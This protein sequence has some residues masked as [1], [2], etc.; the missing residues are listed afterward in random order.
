MDCFHSSF[1]QK[2]EFIYIQSNVMQN[3][4]PPGSPE[5]PTGSQLESPSSELMAQADRILNTCLAENS[6]ANL[7][8][9]I[10]LLAQTWVN[11]NPEDSG[12]LKLLAASLSTRF[13]YTCQWMDVQLAGLMFLILHG[14][15]L[16][17]P[18]I[19]GIL[20]DEL[21]LDVWHNDEGTSDIVAL[22]GNIVANFHQSVNLANLN[23]AIALYESALS[24]RDFLGTNVSRACR[25]LASAQLIQFRVTGEI[26][27]I[28]RSISLLRQLHVVKP[29]QVS[30]LCAALLAK[31]DI[32]NIWDVT[33]LIQESVNSTEKT[34]ELAQI[35]T[36]I[37]QVSHD[38]GDVDMAISALEAAAAK[39]PWGHRDC[40]WILVNLCIALEQRFKRKG[41]LRDLDIAIRLRRDTVDLRP[42]PHPDRCGSLNDLG[43]VLHER[44]EAR[45][46]AADL[47]SAMELHQEAL[48]LC[49]ANHPKRASFFN[50]LAN[51]LHEQ[52]KQGGDAE[53]L[54][55]AI[56]LLD[57]ALN[58]RPPGHPG[59]GNSLNSLAAVLH[60]RFK[61]RGTEGDLDSAIRLHREAFDLFPGPEIR[62]HS[63]NNLAYIL[64]E[65]FQTRGDAGDLDNAIELH[66][67]ALDLRPAPHPNH[68]SSLNNLAYAL[69]ERF[70][71]R[72]EVADL[73][74][75]IVLLRDALDLRPP[76]HPYRA[77]SLN[78]LAGLLYDRLQ[79]NHDEGDLDSVIKLFREA[80]DLHQA[81]HP[82]RGSSLSH[83][84]TVLLQRFKTR[85][86]LQD[87]ETAI[88]L[89][90]EA[91]TIYQ[92][93]H[94]RRGSALEAHARALLDKYDNSQDF[95]ALEG[96][97]M[98]LRESSA[99][100]LT[101]VSQRFRVTTI[102]AWCAE[103]KSHSSALE[104]YE[105][106]IE[107]LPQQ[108]MLGLDIHSRQE[109]L[110]IASVH[111]IVLDAA[112]C[113]T[114]RNDLVKAVQFLEAGRSVFW[115]QALK[116]H[117]S[118]DD[119][120]AVHS[121]LAARIKNIAKKLEVG[122]YRDV[123]SIRML[124]ALHKSHTMLDE[125]NAYYRKL[126]AEWLQT[127]DEVRQLQGFQRFL[128]PKLMTELGAAAMFGPVIILKASKSACTAF[129][130]TLSGEVQAIH[131]TSMTWDKAQ[132][133]VE[134]LHALLSR[135]RVQII[136]TL[137]KIP[138]R[139][140]STESPPLQERLDGSVE[141]SADLDPNKV[142]G[143]LLGE[144][145]TLI[146]Q[147]VFHALKLKK[148]N[149]PSRLWW[150]TTGPFTFLP[151]HAAGL[152]EP[153]RTD[154]VSDYAVSSYTPTLTFLLDQPTRTTP[155]FKMTAVI[156]PETPMLPSLPATKDE[157]T[158]IQLKVPP[159]WLTSL[160][161]T[162]P[163]TVDNALQHLQESS[164]V[165]F[166][167]HGTQDMKNSLES[168]LH[169]SDGRLKLSE[170]MRGKSQNM[171]MTLAFLSACE[172]AKGNETVP[173]EVMHLAATLL[174]T[175]FRGVV[176][177]MWTMADP[178]GPKIAETFYE[179]LFKGCDANATPQVLPDLTKAA[180][181]LHIAVTKLRAD[182]KVPFSRWRN[183]IYD[184]LLPL[185]APLSIY[186]R[187]VSAGSAPERLPKCCLIFENF[188][189]VVACVNVGSGRLDQKGHG[190]PSGDN[191]H[192]S[193]ADM[194][195]EEYDGPDSF[196]VGSKRINP[197]G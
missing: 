62:A 159:S 4:S 73:D 100:I 83:L 32:A 183:I 127:L 173:D 126:N 87:L 59:R 64:H 68:G 133:L 90:Q 67:K 37:L 35:G 194:I 184:K 113:A 34:L 81:P 98:A 78:N 65:R 124:P 79:T 118:L 145:W 146:V 45:G 171:S 120:Q 43:T 157:L 164:V 147:P 172:T 180:E 89:A 85:G 25:Q 168:G 117:T 178:D 2:N 33:R 175:G 188:E 30:Y 49:P 13:S 42:A 130:V 44:F 115:S 61:A 189:M 154:C 74:N 72:G 153:L 109:A 165:H 108:A 93:P 135:S 140:A 17:V 107:L 163:A 3:N 125:D 82:D 23:T 41:D 141:N 144:I 69:H 112:A 106:A 111:S 86:H 27:S 99:Y 15:P 51:V 181:A 166:A 152:Y 148:S 131:L 193:V 170:F 28:D 88:R 84:A 110:K 192:N 40:T 5:L 94:P 186:T 92:P 63:L 129:I 29:S 77:N 182:P 137:T 18:G 26:E 116:L 39:L 46:D 167:C 169:L 136:Q 20:S 105:A 143:W 190:E 57:E 95:N 155:V 21:A 122:S 142:F 158:Q 121:E 132:L 104:A 97:M 7:N 76:G 177:T 56:V 191:G 36:D 55:N 195:V 58:M 139:E 47:N 60:A 176:A 24:A 48:T 91:V 160:G 185:S 101:P 66:R 119:L 54:D 187:S 52:F 22:A 156:Q 123:A 161:D 38:A 75:A 71:A 134:L 179:H 103:L 6:I 151:I 19:Q 138:S 8:T 102:W 174:F 162:S 196:L 149:N 80:L 128:R 9:A 11:Q 50:N 70:Q 12:C 53:D 96:A 197:R 31:P 14:S 150:C 10:Y 1:F 114:R 16:N